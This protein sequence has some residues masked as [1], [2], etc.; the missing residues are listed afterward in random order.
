MRLTMNT[1]IT[2]RI[3]FRNIKIALI[4]VVC[5]SFGCAESQWYAVVDIEVTPGF[6]YGPCIL[7]LL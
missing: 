7:S 2:G 6:M 1:N 4:I 5:R 3:S